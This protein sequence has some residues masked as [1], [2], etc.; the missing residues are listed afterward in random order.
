MVVDTRWAQRA[1]TIRIYAQVD[2]VDI[3]EVGKMQGGPGYILFAKP[4]TGRRF[5]FWAAYEDAALT[6]PQALSAEFIEVEFEDVGFADM[7][8][9]DRDVQP[10]EAV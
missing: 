1:D 7:W 10:Q 4:L 2:D 5:H 3:V 6:P 9:Q 8:A